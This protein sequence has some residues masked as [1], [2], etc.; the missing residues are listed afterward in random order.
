MK[1]VPSLLT[2]PAGLSHWR[3]E[4]PAEDQ[5]TGD[6]AGRAWQ[7]F[8]DAGLPYQELLETLIERQQGLCGYCEQ[9]VTRDDASRV[10]NDY[11]VEHVEA[12][13]SGTGRTLDW[14][15]LMLCCGGGTWPHHVSTDS[16][17]A[18]DTTRYL[19]PTRDNTSCGQ[20]KGDEALPNGCDP[21]V[22]SWQKSL[23]GVGIDG[24]MRAQP[25]ACQQAGVNPAELD[26][27][28]NTRLNLNCERLRL[29]RQAVAENLVEW[30][31]KLEDE[32]LV[33][34][35]LTDDETRRHRGMIV[36]GRLRPDKHGHLR[37]F[38]TTERH[39]LGDLAEA[40]VCDHA[41]ELHF[42]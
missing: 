5:S 31:L 36:A 18:S 27:A 22:F 2:E 8:K 21:R 16:R 24:V 25:A 35:H 23:V 28:I 15:N 19:R 32:L 13:S 4:N 20:A 10:P 37:R 12:K 29:A 42:T 11:Q 14:R 38:W 41:A 1:R 40:W 34:L 17:R 33:Q 9:R 7:R 30:L 26:E 3:A 6:E 39:F